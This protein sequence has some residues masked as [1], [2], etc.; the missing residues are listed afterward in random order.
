MISRF[1]PF[2][3]QGSRVCGKILT[4]A[5]GPWDFGNGFN[6]LKKK[7]KIIFF[8]LLAVSS[9]LILLMF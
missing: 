5:D 4:R 3:F 6:F 9:I 1:S 8:C 7:K 2:K